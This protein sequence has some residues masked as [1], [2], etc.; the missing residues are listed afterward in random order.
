METN[1]GFSA[2]NLEILDKFFESRNENKVA[3]AS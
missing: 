3:N 1:K 2:E